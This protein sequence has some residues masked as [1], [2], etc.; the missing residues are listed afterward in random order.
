MTATKARLAARRVHPPE[1]EPAGPLYV[2]VVTRTIAFAVD[3]AVINL[4]GL[5][6]GAVA[7]LVF[8][9]VPVSDNLRSVLIAAGGVLFVVWGIAYFVTFWTA[10]GETPGNRVMRIRVVRADGGPLRTW[11]ALM[12]LVGIVLSVPLFAGF[13]PILFNDRRRG[14]HD[15]LAGTVV[16]AARSDRL[17]AR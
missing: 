3:A 7:A 13:V 14:L 2:G 12:R 17:P 11:H 15:V 9:V 5:F 16:V 1:E 8:S 4:V 10:T 6:V